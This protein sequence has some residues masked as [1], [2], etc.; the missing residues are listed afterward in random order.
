MA[1]IY[2]ATGGMQ[3]IEALPPNPHPPQSE[4]LWMESW[5]FWLAVSS[6]SAMY[7]YIIIRATVASYPDL[8]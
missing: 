5:L 7:I 6:C 2:L 4:I 1:R 3:V 8:R